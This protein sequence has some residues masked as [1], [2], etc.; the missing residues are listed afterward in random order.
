MLRLKHPKTKFGADR[1]GYM[2]VNKDGSYSLRHDHRRKRRRPGKKFG[3]YSTVSTTFSEGERKFSAGPGS[4]DDDS[5][6]PRSTGYG[7]SHREMHGGGQGRHRREYV[8]PDLSGKDMELGGVTEAKPHTASVAPAAKIDY[9]RPSRGTRRVPARLRSPSP[10]TSQALRSHYRHDGHNTL[11][12][13]VLFTGEAAATPHP[14]ALG[15]QG[16]ATATVAAAAAAADRRASLTRGGF[17]VVWG[18]DAER[19]A[20]QQR[21]AS[22]TT[23]APPSTSTLRRMVQ[24]SVNLRTHEVPR[25]RHV[26]FC[27]GV[28]SGCCVSGCVFAYARTWCCACCS[29]CGATTQKPRR[30]RTALKCLKSLTREPLARSGDVWTNCRGSRMQ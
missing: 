20:A 8:P 17:E 21:D 14:G 15:S 1:S 25:V 4:G 19:G 26:L 29:A 30:L 5:E 23:T 3:M 13:V 16:T 2:R 27:R 24:S 22:G 10:R 28:T 12:S 9:H 6:P 18:D 7:V 11:R